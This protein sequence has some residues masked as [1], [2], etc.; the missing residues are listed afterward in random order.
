[1]E[2]TGD[3]KSLLSTLKNIRITIHKEKRTQHKKDEARDDQ[4][5]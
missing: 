5:R 1:M 4:I 3:F 2:D